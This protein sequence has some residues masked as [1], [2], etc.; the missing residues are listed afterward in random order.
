MTP[1]L[2]ELAVVEDEN[3]VHVLDGGQAVGDGDGAAALHQDPQRVLDE[4]LGVGVDARRRLVE[5][6]HVGREG[7][8]ARERQQLALADRERRPPLPHRRI[9]PLRQPF[10][11]AVRAGRPR[12]RDG[13][14]TSEMEALPRRTFSRTFPEKR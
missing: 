8:R 5:H 3:L 9:E 2:A 7:E 6:E 13:R 10:D 4:A 11:E 12:S 1:D 14:P